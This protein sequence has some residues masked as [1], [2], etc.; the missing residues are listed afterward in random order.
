MIKRNVGRRTDK[1]CHLLDMQ[2]V[3]MTNEGTMDT[4]P[5]QAGRGLV[6]MK[7]LPGTGIMT[8]RREAGGQPAS[9]QRVI[10]L[11]P[12]RVLITT[13]PLPA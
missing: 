5:R 8:L 3:R 12:G 2:A 4:V 10:I 13:S 11:V 1:E 6:T 9:I 7:T